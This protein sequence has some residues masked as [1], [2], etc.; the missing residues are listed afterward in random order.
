M[1][2][3]GNPLW[4]RPS[5]F[6]PAFLA[7][8]DREGCVAFVD[9]ARELGH[10][11]CLLCSCGIIQLSDSYISLYASCVEVKYFTRSM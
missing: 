1:S 11:N 4:A 8:V 2:Q 6:G 7:Y 10:G 3:S 5:H 9:A